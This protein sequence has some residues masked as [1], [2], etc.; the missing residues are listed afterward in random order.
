MKITINDKEIE[1]KQTIRSLLMF[2]NIQGHSYTP[3]SLNDVL[4]YLYCVVVASSK[5]YSFSYDDWIDW[6][7]EHPDELTQIVQFIQQTEETQNDFKKN[8]SQLKEKAKK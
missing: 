5:D 7:D 1:L 2:E 3:K 4:L 6:V 8:K